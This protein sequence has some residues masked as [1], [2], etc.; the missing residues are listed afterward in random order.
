MK[1]LQVKKSQ[2]AQSLADKLFPIVEIDD[3]DSSIINIP[4]E[5]RRLHT[6]SYDFSIATLNDYLKNKTMFVPKFQREYVWNR[7]QASRLIESLIIQCPI[8]VIY[9]NQERDETLAVIDGNQRLTSISLYI[10]NEFELQGL[11]T[12]PELNGVIFADLDSRIQRHILNRT[13]RCITIL[14]ET[15][16]QIKMD[17]FERLNTGAVQLNPQEIRHGVYHGKLIE[18]IDELSNEKIWKK[19]SGIKNDNRMKGSELILRYISLL[20]DL[21]NYKKP[22]KYFLNQFCEKNTNIDDENKLKW[23]NQ[24]LNTIE[25]IHI[26]FGEYAFKTMDKSTNK[27][28][29][30]INAALFDSVMIGFTKAN[31]NSTNIKKINKVKLLKGYQNLLNDEKFIKSISVGTS[32]TTNVKY[33]INTFSKFLKDHID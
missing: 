26:V 6:E 5:K 9:L 22:L 24:F 20:N 1:K 21:P 2:G 17:V 19:I 32:A 3:D 12:Y 29:R 16:P 27:P 28:S 11:T 30:H 25:K 23:K 4:P 18:L 8:P 15:H 13:L 7:T 31:I 10:N 33:R 14:K